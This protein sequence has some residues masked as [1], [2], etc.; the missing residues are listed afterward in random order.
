MEPRLIVLVGPTASGKTALAVR[1]A[2]KFNGEIIAADSRTVYRQMDI[3]TAKP[4]KNERKHIRHHLIDIADP[5]EK[6]TVVQFKRL[7]D[8]VIRDIQNRGKLPILVGGSGL[9]INAVIFDFVFQ[10]APDLGERKRL[11]G[12]SVR[13]LQKEATLHGLDLPRNDQ[14]PRHLIRTIETAGKSPKNDT[15]RPGTFLY[16]LDIA[17]QELEK[18]IKARV[19]QMF[20][21]G[22]LEEARRLKSMYGSDL[23]SMKTYLP[24]VGYLEGTDSL[25]S[26]KQLMVIKDKQLAKKQRT[27]FRRN[28]SI[29][30]FG[31]PKDIVDSITTHMNKSI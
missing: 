21:A 24:V 25:D 12:L 14:N 6:I 27:W 17:P 15:L 11:Q 20:G 13:E 3:A 31:D 18:R 23:E 9:Y 8:N 26:A 2:Q 22:I 1:I 29:Q 4:T 30:W 10:P 5:E 19:E 28:K 16:G 7:A